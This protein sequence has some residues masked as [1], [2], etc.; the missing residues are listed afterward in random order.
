MNK[1]YELTGPEDLTGEQKAT[2]LSAAL[3]RPIKY[4][5]AKK[6]EAFE[7]F[8]QVYPEHQAKGSMELFHLY[9]TGQ[10]HVTSAFK[11]I[12]GQKGTTVQ[13]RF[14]QLKQLGALDSNSA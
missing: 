12:T 2:E 3:G 11:D 8:K 1:A 7:S 5:P 4:I 14:A 9:E 10:V 6:E 13:Q